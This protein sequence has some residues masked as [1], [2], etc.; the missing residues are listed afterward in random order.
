MRG[1][2]NKISDL[3]RGRVHDRV[4]DRVLS[5]A[6]GQVWVRVM[7]LVWSQV[8]GRVLVQI[9]NQI[10]GH[11]RNRVSN[12]NQIKM[13][14]VSSKITQKSAIGSAPTTSAH[15]TNDLIVPIN[16]RVWNFINDQIWFGVYDTVRRRV[17]QLPR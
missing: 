14:E 2:S 4:Y 5:Q 8:D 15:V 9:H 10:S 6:S 11:V 16:K 7:S 12:Q 13:K 3:V 17:G 1:I